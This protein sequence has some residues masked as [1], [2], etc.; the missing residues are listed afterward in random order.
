MPIGLEKS[1]QKLNP[2]ELAVFEQQLN[3]S[4]PKDFVKFYMDYNGGY[5]PESDEDNP[6]LLGGFLPIKYGRVSIEEHYKDITE[7]FPELKELIPFAYDDGG[8]LFLISS[9]NLDSGKIYIW[10]MDETELDFVS[11]SFS[12][13]LNELIEG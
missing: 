4:L 2:D 12:A 11:D 8:N 1:Q 9:K 5:L 7:S 6:Y 10:L 13:F 3:V